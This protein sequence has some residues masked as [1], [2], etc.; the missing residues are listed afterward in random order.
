MEANASNETSVKFMLAEYQDLYQN[1]IHLENKLFSHLSFFTTLLLAVVTASIAILRLVGN[2]TSL[3]SKAG[4]PFGLFL[5]FL[6]FFVVSRFELR[7]TT[8]LRIRKMK[9]IEAIT[10]VRQ[11]FIDND[12]SIADYL[13]LPVGLRKAPPYLRVRSKDWYQMLY[14]SLMNGVAAVNAWLLLF[15]CFSVLLLELPFGGSLAFLVLLLVWLPLGVFIFWFVFWVMSY[16]SSMEF[17]ES[18]DSKRETRMGGKSEYDLLERHL[19]NTRF[20]WTFGDWMCWIEERRK[21]RR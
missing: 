18:Y 12:S 21:V 3:I 7:M 10:Q 11:Y 19:P 13:V 6:L 1:V 20:R 14:I 15:I 2:A 5:L 16:K 4:I 8:E 9:F 17:C